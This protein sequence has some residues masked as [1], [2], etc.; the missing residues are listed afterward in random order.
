[1]TDVSKKCK[2]YFSNLNPLARK[3]FKDVKNYQRT[4][5]ED[6]QKLTPERQEEILDKYFIKEE[7]SNKYT[8]HG[9]ER[10]E[11]FPVY[12]VHCGEKIL[13]DFDEVC[14]IV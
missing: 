8:D 1:M 5:G 11:T 14:L 7:I 2:E 13:V 9:K 3:V 4:F 10:P 6:W 12:R